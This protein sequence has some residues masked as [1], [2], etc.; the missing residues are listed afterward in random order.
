MRS[1]RRPGLPTNRS[2]S[3]EKGGANSAAPFRAF[4]NGVH[5]PGLQSLTPFG[6][7]TPGYSAP[8]FQRGRAR[9][10]GCAAFRAPRRQMRGGATQAMLAHRRGAPTKQMP[11]R[12]QD[13]LGARGLRAN[14]CVA[15]RQRCPTIDCDSDMFG[16]R[17]S[18]AIREFRKTYRMEWIDSSRGDIKKAFNLNG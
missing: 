9:E 2:I 3:P 18:S 7:F 12:R 14:I 15:R 5:Y 8:R 16:Q 17:G 1:I 13:P 6:S 10:L 11:T 4:I